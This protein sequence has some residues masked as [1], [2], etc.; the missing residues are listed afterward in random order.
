MAIQ[1]KLPD[2]NL[3]QI[4]Q[5]SHYSI[6]LVKF[7]RIS[8]VNAKNSNPSHAKLNDPISLDDP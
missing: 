5:N 4:K 6:I 3:A 2:F 1:N 7:L 8:G